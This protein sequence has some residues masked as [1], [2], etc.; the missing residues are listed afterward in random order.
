[1]KHYRYCHRLT[2]RGRERLR[3]EGDKRKL[4]IVYSVPKTNSY[5]ENHY[6]YINYMSPDYYCYCIYK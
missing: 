3:D 4:C 5:S 6:N 1:M 2:V